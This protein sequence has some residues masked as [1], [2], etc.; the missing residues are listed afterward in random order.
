MV[1]NTKIKH[2]YL[3]ITRYTTQPAYLS[4]QLL[5]DQK[6]FRRLS[7]VKTKPSQAKQSKAN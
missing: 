5:F 2:I 4:P 3:L 6:I 1:K 7:D